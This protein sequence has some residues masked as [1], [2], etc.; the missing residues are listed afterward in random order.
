MTQKVR[1]PKLSI[2]YIFG[3]AAGWNH[4]CQSVGCAAIA[5]VAAVTGAN[6]PAS[7]PTTRLNSGLNIQN[8][9]KISHA[10]GPRLIIS[11]A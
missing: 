3:E 1:M 7:K 10:D 2:A 4:H 8:F 9:S 11:S 6:T 5:D